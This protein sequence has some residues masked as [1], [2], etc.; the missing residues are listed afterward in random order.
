MNSRHWEY[1]KLA[2]N[3]INLH[4]WEVLAVWRLERTTY[5]PEEEVEAERRYSVA[6]GWLYQVRDSPCGE[7]HPP[8]Y[9]P[10]PHA[11]HCRQIKEHMCNKGAESKIKRIIEAIEGGG[12]YCDTVDA[13]RAIL[14]MGER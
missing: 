8:V 1:V 13:I 10:S 5:K 9:V 3:T 4:E 11:K 12:E 14:G 7:W 6:S 2:P